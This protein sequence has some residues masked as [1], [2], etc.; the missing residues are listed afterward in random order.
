MTRVEIAGPKLLNISRQGETLVVRRTTPP[1]GTRLIVVSILSIIVAVLFSAAVAG[2]SV[3]TPVRLVFV[4][5]ALLVV[6]LALR[7]SDIELYSAKEMIYRFNK[8]TGQVERNGEEIAQLEDVDHI[9]VRR[10]LKDESEDL[11]KS[12][13]ALVVALENTKRF[14]IAETQ[15][16]PGGRGQVNQAAEEIAS[17]LG[18]S[19]RQG[20]RLPG[21]EWMDR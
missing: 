16:L 2:S 20:E 3:S 13:Y 7:M 11:E 15:G 17:F 12:D 4:L 21:E 10:I 18:V 8:R 9:L 14:T 1:Y 19:V 6:L 5:A